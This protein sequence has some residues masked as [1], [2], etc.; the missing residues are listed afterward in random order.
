MGINRKKI[1]IYRNHYLFWYVHVR[2]IL[3]ILFDLTLQS[4]R[5]HCHGHNQLA[6]T[7]K[8]LEIKDVLLKK[9]YMT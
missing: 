6:G 5:T 9:I 1:D 7:L 2:F 3:A 8:E 4:A